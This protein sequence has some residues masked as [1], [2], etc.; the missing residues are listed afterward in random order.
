[1]DHEQQTYIHVTKEKIK[2]NK[3]MLNFYLK[4]AGN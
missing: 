1:M 4:P 3:R 2:Y